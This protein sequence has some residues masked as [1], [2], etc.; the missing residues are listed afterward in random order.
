MINK[1]FQSKSLLFKILIQLILFFYVATKNTKPHHT[2]FLVVELIKQSSLIYVI[3][4]S[5]YVS[6]LLGF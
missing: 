5:L 1:L 4:G 2:Y 6:I 3:I